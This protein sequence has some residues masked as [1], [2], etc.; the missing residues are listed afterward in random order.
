[1]PLGQS[2]HINFFGLQ[3]RVE[4][5]N[6]QSF[7]LLLDLNFDRGIFRGIANGI[8]NENDQ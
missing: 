5:S 3:H 7:L 8:L 2:L 1:M 6:F 4:D